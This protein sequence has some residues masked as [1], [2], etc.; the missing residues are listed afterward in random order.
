MGFTK[1]EH[2]LVSKNLPALLEA[3]AP[4]FKRWAEAAAQQESVTYMFDLNAVANRMRARYAPK[5]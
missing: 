3:Q 5:N 2:G 4:R 1:P